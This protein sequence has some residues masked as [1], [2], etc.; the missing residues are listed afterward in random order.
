MKSVVLLLLLSVAAIAQ[1]PLEPIRV[2]VVADDQEI[3]SHFRGELRKRRDVIAAT[4]EADIEIYLSVM[5]L[6]EEDLCA[7]Y[8][9]AILIVDKSTGRHKLSIDTGPHLR[10]M[11]E[12]MAAKVDFQR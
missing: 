2:R 4:K 12:R 11:A 10:G 6:S 1:K 3:A 8:V 7:G 5:K 9:A